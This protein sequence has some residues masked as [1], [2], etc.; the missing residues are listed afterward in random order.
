MLAAG[1]GALGGFGVWLAITAIRGI[2]VVPDAR[3]MVPKTVPA[4]KS[5]L[6]LATALVSGVVVGL[7]TG[8]PVAGIGT[9]PIP[10]GSSSGKMNA[11]LGEQSSPLHLT[12]PRPFRIAEV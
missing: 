8:W 7:V 4:E 12:V 9:R 1:V 5:L 2:R 10:S 3:R 6:W 11:C